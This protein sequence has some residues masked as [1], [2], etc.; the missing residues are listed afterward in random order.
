MQVRHSGI[1]LRVHL[2]LILLA[3]TGGVALLLFSNSS[4]NRAAAQ[5]NQPENRIAFNRNGQ[6]FIVN[7]DDSAL[8][9]LGQGFNPSWSKTETGL[10][11]IA[12]AYGP[13]E[14][15]RIAVMDE[16]GTNL[17]ELT[18]PDLSTRTSQP[19]LSPG[20]TRIAFVNEVLE[21][22]PG[23]PAPVAHS[24]IYTVDANGQNFLPLFTGNV[25][26]GTDHEFFPAWS[27]DGTRI[28]FIGLRDGGSLDLYVAN[29]DG[30]TPP[31]K[32]TNFGD[33]RIS[34]GQIAWSPDGQRLAFAAT[35]DIYVVNADGTDGLTN[36][37]H[38]VPGRGNLDPA[39]SP[40]GQKIAYSQNYAGSDEFDGLYVMDADGQNPI[41]LNTVGSEPTWEP[42]TF[43]PTPEADVA[44]ELSASPNAVAVGQNL[45]YTMVIRNNGPAT[46]ESVDTDFVRSASLQLVSV[47]PAQGS[48]GLDANPLVCQLGQLGAGAQTSIQVIVRPTAA[49]E[50]VTFAGVRAQTPD[51]NQNNNSQQHAITVGQS[52]VP[53]V[54][55]QVQ[56]ATIRLG[57][58]SRPTVRHTILMRNNSGRAL[59][60]FVHLVF[61]GLPQSVESGDPGNAFRRTQCAPP[62]GRKYTTV[63][64]GNMVWRPGQIIFANVEFSNPERVRVDY[65][66]RVYVGPDEP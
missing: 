5:S 61:D 44:V 58:Q 29:A 15:T 66:L 25:T 18:P 40:D 3:V 47:S 31:V 52:C 14:F 54:T 21:T 8:V 50:V 23:E 55:D 46:A 36:L 34:L 16:D 30:Q 7:P 13:S 43:A 42:R 35:Q 24:R 65:R 20:A 19:D 12:F 63:R 60:G 53:E 37:T 48:C 59:N 2:L 4:V 33:T 11:K 32:I 51:S 6:I 17:V 62:L 56:R 27:A 26:S 39:W 41:F 45:T 10:G 38:T 28:A 57:S 64:L 22:D 9:P 1:K 49:G